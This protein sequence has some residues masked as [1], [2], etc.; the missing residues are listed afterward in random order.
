MRKLA[1]AARGNI[2]KVKKG[3]NSHC[4]D[5]RIDTGLYTTVAFA[6]EPEASFIAACAP[7]QITAMCDLIEAQARRIEE[8]TKLVEP[9]RALLDRTREYIGQTN[10]ELLTWWKD[11]DKEMLLRARAVERALSGIDALLST[12]GAS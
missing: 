11:C 7:S 1:E 9:A 3:A 12:P 6:D 5:L 2:W 10:P 4:F 8:L